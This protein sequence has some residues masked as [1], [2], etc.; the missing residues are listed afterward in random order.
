MSKKK[1]YIACKSK[2]RVGVQI[3]EGTNPCEVKYSTSVYQN[4]RNCSLT[5]AFFQ[6]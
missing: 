3:R 6:N 5:S 2:A 1:I 4:Q